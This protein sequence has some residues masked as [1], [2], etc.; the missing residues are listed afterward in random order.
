MSHSCT[1]FW[2]DIERDQILIAMDS[3]LCAVADSNGNLLGKTLRLNLGLENCVSF[4]FEGDAIV[5][6]HYE[7]RWLKSICWRSGELLWETELRKGLHRID[8]AG[9]GTVVASSYDRQVCFVVDSCT[10]QLKS[11]LPGYAFVR[12]ETPANGRVLLQQPLGQR[13]ISPLTMMYDSARARVMSEI[14][15]IRDE[16]S[17][18][19]VICDTCVYGS[20]ESFSLSC[21]DITKDITTWR[22]NVGDL[23]GKHARRDYV[24]QDDYI[25]TLVTVDRE[26]NC[27]IALCRQTRVSYDRDRPYILMLSID[28]GRVVHCQR[29]TAGQLANSEM[30]RRASWVGVNGMW[31]ISDL[32]WCPRRWAIEERNL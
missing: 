8:S 22:H 23:I 26:R 12:A 32:R 28:D 5:L 20:T 15:S 29:I 2:A 10:G 14:S 31:R 19:D 11:K 24:D 25:C 7:H 1:Q 30:N 9:P 18:A 27:A 16:C 3:G 6:A 4:T 13:R 17:V 21:V